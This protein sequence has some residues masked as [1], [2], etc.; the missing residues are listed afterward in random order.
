M[1]GIKPKKDLFQVKVTTASEL[2]SSSGGV[3]QADKYF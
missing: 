3:F 2:M 1:N